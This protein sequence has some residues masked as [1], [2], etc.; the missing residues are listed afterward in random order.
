MFWVQTALKAEPR[1]RHL[2]TAEGLN[3]NIVYCAMQDSKGYMWFGTYN[4]LCRYDGYVFTNYMN[5]P[6][7]STSINSGPVRSICEGKDGRIWI[8]TQTDGVGIYD[9]KTGFKKLI[10]G[11]NITCMSQDAFGAFWIG[12]QNNGLFRVDMGGRVFQLNLN[13]EEDS[14]VTTQR[15]NSVT[16]IQVGKN[17]IVWIGSEASGL[18]NFDIKKGTLNHIKTSSLSSNISVRTIAFGN[19]NQLYIGT[20]YSVFSYQISTG[21]MNL[22]LDKNSQDSH[23]EY[24]VSDLK[25]YE[26]QLWISTHKDGLFYS[27]KTPKIFEDGSFGSNGAK[28]SINSI[29]F[30][31][32]G[33]LWV[34]TSKGIF[35]CS[36]TSRNFTGIKPSDLDNGFRSMYAENDSIIWI[37]TNGKGL[38]KI[39]LN[40]P[41][42][43]EYFLY[44]P[45]TAT[46]TGWNNVNSIYPDKNFFWISTPQ[47]VFKFDRTT[48]KFIAFLLPGQSQYLNNYGYSAWQILRKSES[49]GLIWISTGSYGLFSYNEK[50]KEFV[51]Y[52]HEEGVANSLT[53]NTVWSLFEDS[54]KRLWVG[55]K[56]GLELFQNGVFKHYGSGDMVWQI[57][58]DLHGNIWYITSNN[59]LK[60]LNK[61][62]TKITAYS[63]KDGLPSNVLCGLEVD[64]DGNFWLSSINGLCK[65]NPVTGK[66]VR[67]FHENDGLASNQFSFLTSSSTKAGTLFFGG[68]ESITYF[69]PFGRQQ[70]YQQ[71][72]LVLTGFKC[73]SEDRLFELTDDS[74][75]HLKWNENAIS[76]DFSY[77]DFIN[78]DA[79]R[80]S[81]RLKGLNNKW[82]PFSSSHS[83]NFT[84][85]EHGNYVFEVRAMNAEGEISTQTFSYQIIINEPFWTTWWFTLSW[86]LAAIAIPSIYVYIYIK[87][88]KEKRQRILTELNALRNQLNPHFVFNSLSSLQHFIL[89]NNEELALDYLG[90]FSTLM[91]MILS[92]SRLEYITVAEEMKFLSLY[93]YMESIRFDNKIEFRVQ[94]AENI[95]PEIVHLPPMMLQPLIENSIKHGLV[96]SL[97]GEKGVIVIDFI[98]ED[99]FLICKVTDNGV[100]LEKAKENKSKTRSTHIS[101]SSTIIHERLALLKSNKNKTGN[102]AY[103]NLYKPDG[104]VAGT[105]A[106]IKIPQQNDRNSHP[107][108]HH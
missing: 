5:D 103:E 95:N 79:N 40:F 88:E 66:A 94:S 8:G 13:E 15:K 32:S 108:H 45:Y 89:R 73:Q 71:S 102:L 16:A 27:E 39:N 78:P 47:G 26:N 101:L 41:S 36:A 17:N 54:K 74:F 25:L 67:T 100:G 10:R 63:T 46:N 1:Y 69:K 55:T 33:G 98:L 65:F 50:T 81:Y 14:T 107:R 56:S 82:S 80:Y 58:E 35:I 20:V 68:N 96:S 44:H 87:K 91:R 51:N 84:N 31:K 42:K 2:T 12:S 59:G 92:N 62:L 90:K 70:N 106:I 37:G 85:L 7:D 83:I 34:C 11:T 6:A 23:N 52:R 99:E 105:V 76:F 28:P 29:C 77:L 38:K 64:K 61:N 75:I 104:T 19:E 43:P 93:V 9:G 3:G 4:G 21:K 86:I 60:C 97:S 24:S 22:V 72:K 30:D 57:T 18:W 48:K 53:H 49:D